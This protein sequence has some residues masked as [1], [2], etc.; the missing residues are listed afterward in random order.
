MPAGNVPNRW[1]GH[2]QNH[3]GHDQPCRGEHVRP[4]MS[5]PARPSNRCAASL[6]REPENLARLMPWKRSSATRFSCDDPAPSAVASA[7]A[8]GDPITVFHRRVTSPRDLRVAAAGNA[9]VCVTVSSA[10]CS[11]R[12]TAPPG[13]RRCRSDPATS[14]ISLPATGATARSTSPATQ[15]QFDPKGRMNGLARVTATAANSASPRVSSSRQF[16]SER[17]SGL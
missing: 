4:P 8:S 9:I 5:F 3:L 14:G 7:T 17:L 16:D 10:A 1:R 15:H 2:D 11:L 13:T 12:P 6:S